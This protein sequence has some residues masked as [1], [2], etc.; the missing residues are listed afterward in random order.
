M[1]KLLTPFLAILAIAGCATTENFEKK[2]SVYVGQTETQL[3]AAEGIPASMY[4]NEG[5][6][7]LTYTRTESGVIPG[8]PPVISTTYIA[9][10]PYTR[11]SG[12]TQTIG[13]T[14]SC[15][16]TFTIVNK[17]VT[18]YQYK[19]NSCRAH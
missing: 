9:G 7:Y 8:T 12:G 3:V 17:I 5:T 11:S 16:V 4:E 6:R 19:G 15:S 14:N 1:T 18:G 10:K 2:V 13:Y